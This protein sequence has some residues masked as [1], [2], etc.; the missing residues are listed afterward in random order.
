MVILCVGGVSYMPPLTND[1]V[2]DNGSCNLSAVYSF[3]NNL[4]KSPISSTAKTFPFRQ[5]GG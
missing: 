4:I 5:V 3:L 2:E 1:T